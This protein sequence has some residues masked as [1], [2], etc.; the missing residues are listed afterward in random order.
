MHH[1]RRGRLHRRDLGADARR[2]RRR[3][4]SCSATPSAASCFG[5]TDRA[6]A[7]KV[8]GGARR[9]PRCRSSASARPR[10]SATRGDTERKL[11]HQ[12]Q[13][14][15]AKVPDERL[16]EVVIAY[17]PIWAIGTGQVAT[18]E[19]AQEAIALH[20]RA[21][22]R[23]STRRPAERGADPLRRLGQARQRRRAAGAARRRRRAR[24]RRVA[25][26]RSR[27]RRSSTAARDERCRRPARC[28]SRASAWSCSTAGGSRRAGPGQRRLAGRHA[29]V[30]RAVGALPAHAADRLRARASGCPRGRW[31]TPRSA[32][33][34]SARARSCARTSTRI[35][36]A[37]ADGDAGR[38][39][40]AA[41]GVRR[42]R[43]RVHLIGL[44]SD[45]G[46]HSSLDHL[47][48]A[49][50]AGRAS[51]ASTT[52]SSTPSPTAAT[53]SPH[54]R[55]RL[56]RDG[57]GLVRGAGDARVGS[58]VGRYFA[59][60]RDRAGTARRRP[61]TCSSTARAEHHADSGERGGRATPTSAARP[62]SSSSR[63]SSATEARIRPGDTR[64]RVQLPPRPHAPDHARAR[65]AGLRRDRPRRR[66]S[67]SSAT[68]R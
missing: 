58:V 23:P 35:D 52:S 57:R 38:E 31:A 47:R 12:V 7:L 36:D 50:R 41:R 26:R 46:V 30:R 62:T 51:W 27:S 34:T 48:G 10:R 39:R 18:P 5:E 2:A 13:E 28:R 42:T 53:R 14:D 43:A 29:G 19:Q 60:D 44:V 61:T 21:R 56:P 66:A 20:P 8:P 15:L 63:R 24:R 4:A 49:D 32:T 6:L 40:G 33:S 55:R 67:R 45:G 59:M 68:R 65:R 9:R 11:R 3:T 64:D 22:R 1:E 54:A 37:V 16:A 17:E 25:R